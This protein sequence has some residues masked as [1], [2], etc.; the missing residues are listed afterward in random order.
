M[1]PTRGP[2]TAH[3]QLDALKGL[4]ASQQA[5]E[6][7]NRCHLPRWHVASIANKRQSNP[8]L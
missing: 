7:L 1:K 4:Q 3:N 2:S 8:R 6:N 5:L